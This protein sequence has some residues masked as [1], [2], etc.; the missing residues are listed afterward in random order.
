MGVGSGVRKPPAA[1]KNSPRLMSCCASG[2]SAVTDGVRK[3]ALRATLSLHRFWLMGCEWQVVK[4]ESSHGAEIQTE[5]IWTH[6]SPP[7]FIFGGCFPLPLSVGNASAPFCSLYWMSKAVPNLYTQRETTVGVFSPKLKGICLVVS[8]S[9]HTF[10]S[11]RFLR[12][13]LASIER[14]NN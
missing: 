12:S 10:T 7:Y 9:I 4:G 6:G 2:R 14:V 5:L 1:T 11:N 13:F 3:A 8:T